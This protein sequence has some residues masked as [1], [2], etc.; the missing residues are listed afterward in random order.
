MSSYISILS[1]PS[2]FA[3]ARRFEGLP[4]FLPL[5]IFRNSCGMELAFK[6]AIFGP[7]ADQVTQPSQNDVLFALSGHLHDDE[8]R[9]Q[10]YASENLS[11]GCQIPGENLTYL[12]AHEVC[13]KDL[14]QNLH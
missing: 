13:Q 11:R 2:I 10:I 1:F 6:Q 3:Y 8:M 9:V 5:G 4:S 12:S 7:S 14:V